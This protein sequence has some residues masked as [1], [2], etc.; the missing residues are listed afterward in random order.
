MKDEMERESGEGKKEGGTGE[1]GEGERE[2]APLMLWFLPKNGHENPTMFLCSYS[3]NSF[4]FS[5]C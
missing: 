3:I 4:L 2:A 1:E 5:L